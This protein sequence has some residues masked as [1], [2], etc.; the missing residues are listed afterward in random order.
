MTPFD[1]M[2]R[3]LFLAYA[4][5]GP[6]LILVPRICSHQA[7]Y[8]SP[9]LG[10]PLCRYLRTHNLRSRRPPRLL[11]RVPD[12]ADDEYSFHGRAIYRV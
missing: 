9:Q 5:G 10:I 1:G 8:A 4:C 7:A 3:S 11:R 6:S 2:C 12:N